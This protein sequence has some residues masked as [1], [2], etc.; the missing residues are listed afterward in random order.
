MPTHAANSLAL[1]WQGLFP[2]GVSVAWSN[3][4]AAGDALLPSERR[5]TRGM[6]SHRL[7]SFA[8]GRTCARAALAGL[9]YRESPVPVG[10]QRAPLWP[11]GIAGSI[12]H[13]AGHSLAVACRVQVARSVGI[14]LE[15]TGATESDVLALVCTPEERQ[16]LARQACPDAGRVLFAIKESIYKCLWP[17]TR[18]YIDFREVEVALDPDTGRYAAR[19]MDSRLHAPTVAA[20]RGGW[21]T[22]GSFVLTS[23]Y[24]P[25]VPWPATRLSA[26]SANVAE[27]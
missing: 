12:T 24:L 19:A 22:T 1:D 21:R 8:Q 14:D 25:P 20:I 2:Q 16:W 9:G 11:R 10:E 6:A 26:T 23:A 3:T 4:P 13:R 18:R 15:Q 5:Y 17:L 27:P 7:A